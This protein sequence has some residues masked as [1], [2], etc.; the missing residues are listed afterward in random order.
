MNLYPYQDKIVLLGTLFLLIILKYPVAP[1]DP[2][3][4]LELALSPSSSAFFIDRL[5]LISLIKVFSLIVGIEYAVYYLSVVTTLT[6]VYVS[7]KIV[8]SDD[9]GS[10]IGLLVT[11][12]FC[13]VAMSNMGYG[14]PTQVGFCLQIS[15]FYLVFFRKESLLNTFV[16]TFLLT[17]LLFSKIQFFPSALIIGF[18][19]IFRLYK[20]NKIGLYFV[21][22][23]TSALCYL[24]VVG[25]V[26]DANLID[27]V[28]SY[29]SGEF[30]KQYAGRNAGGLPPFYIL[31]FEPAFVMATIGVV[32][33]LKSSF[34]QKYKILAALAVV[35]LMFLLGIFVITGRGGPV[36]FNYFY[37][38]YFIGGVLFYMVYI[39][40]IN[41]NNIRLI[42]LLLVFF[43]V[44]SSFLYPIGF[45]YLSFG[46]YLIYKA[47][48]VILGLV[49]FC[50]YLFRNKL[51]A[52]PIIILLVLFVGPGLSAIFEFNFKRSLSL[53]YM[54]VLN[55]IEYGEQFCYA[56]SD[57]KFLNRYMNS[58]FL[59]TPNLKN[60][61]T[62]FCRVE[63]NR[64]PISIS[65][66]SIRGFYV[67]GK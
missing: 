44:A 66:S 2:L 34:D 24:F 20:S 60:M 12:F 55:S 64:K 8:T 32:G 21:T 56:E 51:K 50:V 15:V 13:Y 35:D 17:A 6:S 27:L 58:S 37:S 61:S 14:Y 33:V 43:I 52:S 63:D 18:Y 54:T 46:N 57:D 23:I 48:F 3:Q 41:I 62:Y 1:S 38:Y 40:D 31:V 67:K 36:I 39:K 26:L 45:N 19:F 11:L 22:I 5:T 7:F 53:S 49:F 47:W 9:K 30:S 10:F 59:F 28:K 29:F 4:Y 16:T 25:L 42:F 65:R